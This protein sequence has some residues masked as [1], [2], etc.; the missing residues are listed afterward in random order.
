MAAPWARRDAVLLPLTVLALLL[1]AAAVPAAGAD[2]PSPSES[3]QAAPRLDEALIDEALQ[4]LGRRYVDD[5]ALDT[6]T[7]TRGAIRGM[8]EALGD[9]GHTE[10]LTP[11]EQAAARDALD[12]RVMGI[13]V[14]LDQR[15]ATPLVI[16]VI[17]GSP[18]DRAGLQDGDVITGVDGVSTARLPDEAFAALVRGSVGSDVV[19]EIERPGVP[20]PMTFTIVREDVAIEPVAWARVPGSSVAVVRIVQFSDGAGERTRE[21]IAAALEAGAQGI[22]LDLR[23]N[24]GGLVGEA[25]DVVAAFLD[26]GVAYQEQGRDGPAREVEVPADRTIAAQTPLSV[27]VD[28]GTAS[29]AEI[30]AAALRDNGRASIVGEQTFGTG[31]VVHTFDL[32]DGSALKVG[33]LSWMTPRGETVFGVG[34]APDH[35]VA[36]PPGARHLRPSELSRMSAADV[37]DSGDIPLRRAIGLLEPLTSD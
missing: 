34:I 21:A 25:V 17:D 24:P 11:E 22:V 29:S 28:Y 6:E 9:E 37:A 20:D 5:E 27:L 7:L 14:V 19:L 16:A 13:G 10:Y 31:T 30:L 4:V 33:V 15:S 3:P 8:L 2:H 23:G 36:S 35:V 18:A 12:G 26:G 1:V 32:S